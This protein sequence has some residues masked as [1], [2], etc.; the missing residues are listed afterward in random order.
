MSNEIKQSVKKVHIPVTGMTCSTCAATI[1]K[2]LAKI[3]GVK[4]VRVNFASEKATIEY[5]PAKIKPCTFKDAISDLGYGMATKKSIFPVTGMTC[6]SCVSHVEKALASIPGVVS[7]NVNLAS[8]KATVE[9]IDGTKVTQLRKA[10][11]DAGYELG[12]EAGTLEDVT[13]VA[14]RNI[15]ALRNR[16]IFL[17][18]GT[19]LWA[20]FYRAALSAL[21]SGDTRTVLGRITILQGGMGSSKAEKS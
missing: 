18:P 14:K 6:A 12:P 20:F 2:G 16:V 1:E 4:E 5:D 13:V 9:Y 15:H 8:E 7:V 3:P 17:N 19:Q 10:V 11:K 21:G